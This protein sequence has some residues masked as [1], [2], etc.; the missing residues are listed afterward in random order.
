MSFPII[1]TTREKYRSLKPGNA[2]PREGDDRGRKNNARTSKRQNVHSGL[3]NAGVCLG[4]HCVTRDL[5]QGVSFLAPADKRQHWHNKEARV[6]RCGGTG[7]GGGGRGG[8][9]V[10]TWDSLGPFA[11]LPRAPSF[12]LSPSFSL[13]SARRA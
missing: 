8:G 12:S 6:N 3:L 2:L 13:A 11:A 1:I 7:G 10:E 9:R 5:R 4:W